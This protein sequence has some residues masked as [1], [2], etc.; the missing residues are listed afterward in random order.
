MNN[1]Y[2]KPILVAEIGCNHKG[3]INLAKQLI[4]S[5][6]NCGAQYAKFQIRDNKYLL[7]DDYRSHI[8][9][10]KTRMGKLFIKI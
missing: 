1:I 2:H 10:Q 9:Y 5:A 4:V 7:G 6:A 3:D 8:Q